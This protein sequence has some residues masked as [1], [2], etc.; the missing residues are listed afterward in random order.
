MPKTAKRAA[1]LTD[2]FRKQDV[3]VSG[4]DSNAILR[5]LMDTDD[6]DD[7]GRRRARSIYT[8]RSTKATGNSPSGSIE[9]LVERWGFN[10][11]ALIRARGFME[12]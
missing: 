12:E 7:V 2:G 5:D 4:R 9:E 10:D 8:R 3:F 11:P 1:S 6:R